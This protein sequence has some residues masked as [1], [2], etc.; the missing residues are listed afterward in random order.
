MLLLRLG[1]K[2]V[3]Q[4]PAL[5]VG[6]PVGRYRCAGSQQFFNNHIARKGARLRTAVGFGQ[7]HANPTPGTEFPAEFG[8]ESHPGLCAQAGRVIGQ[9]GLDKLPNLCAKRL[10]LGRNIAVGKLTDGHMR[11]LTLNTGAIAS[12]EATTE[13]QPPPAVA[14]D[15]RLQRTAATYNAVC[16]SAWANIA[17]MSPE[18]TGLLS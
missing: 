4:W 10:C 17:L 1:A 18:V 5:T 8:V 16:A 12:N 13:R 6:D 7:C 11:S 9:I 3:D 14:V 2:T 15:R